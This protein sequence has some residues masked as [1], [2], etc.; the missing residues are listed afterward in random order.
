[1]NVSDIKTR[2][3]RSFHDVAN[4]QIAPEDIIKWINDGQR[5][6]VLESEGILTTSTTNSAVAGTSTY[7]LPT[8][9][10]VLRSIQFKGSGEQSFYSL[11]YL[12]RQE[13]DEYIDGWNGTAYSRSTPTVYTVESGQIVLFPTPVANGTSNIKIYYSRMPTDVAL[14]SDTPSLPLL[15][16]NAL[17]WYCL[18]QAYVLDQDWNAAGNAAQAFSSDILKLRGRESNVANNWEAYP[19]ITVLNDDAW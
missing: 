9:L 8:D 19:H 15:Y 11:E 5:K 13:F 4:V 18:Q 1:M 2:V 12:S 10:L 7:S 14:D 3:F 17:V 6:I 16:H